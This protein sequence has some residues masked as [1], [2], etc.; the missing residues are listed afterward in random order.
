MSTKIYSA[1]KM[2][3]RAFERDF[4]PAYR[5]AAFTFAEKL[6]RVALPNEFVASDVRK[7]LSLSIRASESPLRG[8]PFLIDASLNAWIYSGRIYVIPYAQFLYSGDFTAPPEAHEYRY[9]NNTDRPGE[10]TDRE[11]GNRRK[12]WDRVCLDD[13][14]RGRMTHQVIEAKSNVGLVDVAKRLLGDELAWPA[15]PISGLDRNDS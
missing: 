4:L 6:M 12:T 13:W 1:W 5:D 15:V 14:D 2:S 3:P 8:E 9:W 11:W 7:L 10:I